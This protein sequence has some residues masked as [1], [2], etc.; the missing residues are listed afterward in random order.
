MQKQF[1]RKQQ[2]YHRKPRSMWFNLGRTD[3]WWQNM[4]LN[5]IRLI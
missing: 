1:K 5:V 3:K 2:K 4:F